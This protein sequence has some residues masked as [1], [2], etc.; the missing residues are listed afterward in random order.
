MSDHGCYGGQIP[1]SPI[2]RFQ[3]EIQ[4][5]P[6]SPTIFNVVVN[7]VLRHWVAVVSEEVAEPDSFVQAVLNM[8]DIF[9]GA[10]GL[11]EST[12][13][14]WLKRAFNTLVALFDR[15]GLQTNV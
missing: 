3:G 8:A 2:Q 9:Y 11:L 14:K 15:V 7:A 10:H 13:Y 5:E 6:L 1:Y 4:G 12:R